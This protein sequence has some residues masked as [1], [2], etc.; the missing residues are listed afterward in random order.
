MIYGIGGIK[1]FFYFKIVLCNIGTKNENKI[2]YN[3]NRYKKYL[4]TEILCH[5]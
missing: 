2:N 1:Q 3:R 5:S 4:Y